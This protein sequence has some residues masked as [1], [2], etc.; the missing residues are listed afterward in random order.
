MQFLRPTDW[1]T[2]EKVSLIFSL[3]KKLFGID[4]FFFSFSVEELSN[5]EDGSQYAVVRFYGY[6]SLNF[7]IH[8]LKNALL[9]FLRYFSFCV[10][11]NEFASFIFDKALK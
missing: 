7:V 10:C 2:R 9:I 8:N 6:V 4:N 5:G 1:N 11:V 3:T